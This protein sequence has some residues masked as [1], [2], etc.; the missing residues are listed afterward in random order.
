MNIIIFSMNRACQLDNLLSSLKMNYVDYQ[1]SKINVVYK[2]TNEE[3][4]LGYRNCSREHPFADFTL[5]TNFQK[6]VVES[7]DVSRDH[8]MFLVDDILVLRKFSLSDPSFE[9]SEFANL[10]DESVVCHSL[11]LHPG[12][13]E[14]YS[15][16]QKETN[17]K[18][19][20]YIGNL[21]VWNWREQIADWAYPMSVDGHIFKSRFIRKI[22]EKIKYSNPNTFE[23][24]MSNLANAG[25][26]QAS[27][28]TCSKLASKLLN[29]PVNIVQNEFKNKHTN[30]HNVDVL[31]KEYL[32][33]RRLSFQ[34]LTNH[35][36]TSVHVDLPL[37]WKGNI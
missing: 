1:S 4:G 30:T 25:Y 21:M 28:M 3:M 13:N 26:I 15:L 27:K 32:A 8:T 29:I 7:I 14:C 10:K 24:A 35:I 9:E 22:S 37:E 6:N 19:P 2:Y 18:N 36:N 33:G 34:H 23:A 11:R 16:N 17:V 5:E 20:T 12:I 31:N